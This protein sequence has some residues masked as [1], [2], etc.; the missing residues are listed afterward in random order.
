M[1][2][3]NYLDDAKM[4]GSMYYGTCYSSSQYLATFTG[5]NTLFKPTIHIA[6]IARV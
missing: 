1:D 4:R 6:N 3:K 2:L 5:N